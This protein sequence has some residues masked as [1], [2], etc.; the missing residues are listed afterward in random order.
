MINKLLCNFPPKTVWFV[1]QITQSFVY[2]KLLP[3]LPKE[4]KGQILNIY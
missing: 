3:A 4:L 2:L 1:S